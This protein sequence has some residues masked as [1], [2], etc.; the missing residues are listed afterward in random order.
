MGILA[1]RKPTN[2]CYNSVI[3]Q[4]MIKSK[5]FTVSLLFSI[6]FLFTSSYI[7]F[8]TG[9]NRLFFPAISDWKQY[10]T[11]KVQ[12]PDSKILCQEYD[13]YFGGPLPTRYIKLSNCIDNMYYFSPI[14]TIIDL[15]SGTLLLY[16]SL[17]YIL[18]NI[19]P[20]KKNYLLLKFFQ[21]HKQR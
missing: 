3:K 12:L 7:G 1:T 8:N 6:I 13:V 15:L 14:S 2:S 18:K 11:V 20:N 21:S 10:K 9:T 17:Y 19:K 4:K 16:I 5:I